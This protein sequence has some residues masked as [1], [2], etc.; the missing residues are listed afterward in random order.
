[1]IGQRLRYVE[2]HESVEE[3][4]RTLGQRVRHD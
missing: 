4:A 2:H 3:G 1:V